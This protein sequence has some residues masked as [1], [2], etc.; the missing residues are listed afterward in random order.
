MN[1]YTENTF[2]TK[3]IKQQSTDYKWRQGNLNS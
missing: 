2:V 3:L 1:I